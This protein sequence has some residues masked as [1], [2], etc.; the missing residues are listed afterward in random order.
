MAQPNANPRRCFFCALFA[1]LLAVGCQ[2]PQSISYHTLKEPLRL[3]GRLVQRIDTLR[4]PP[5]SDEGAIIIERDGTVLDLGGGVL[6]GADSQVAPENFVGRGIVVRGAKN[7][8]LRNVRVEGFKVG[9]YAEDAPGLTIENCDVSGNYRQRLLSTPFQENVADWLWPHK[10]DENE[11]LRY[12]SGI[13]LLRCDGAKLKNNRARRGQNGI[14]LSK[15]RDVTVEFCDMS[16]L[17]GWGLALWRSTECRILG[18]R[19][20]YCVRGFSAGRFARGQDSAGILMFEQCSD[21]IIAFNSATHGG[22][23]LFIYGGDETL[24]VTGEGG[25]NRNFVFKNDFSHAVMNGIEATFSDDN[26]FVSNKLVDCYHGFWGGYCNKFNLTLNEFANC[27]TGAVIEHARNLTLRENSFDACERGLHLWWDEDRNLAEYAFVKKQGNACK[28]IAIEWCEFDSSNIGIMI[29]TVENVAMDLNRLYYCNAALI[30]KGNTN[31]SL[32]ENLG[33]AHGEIVNETSKPMRGKSAWMGDTVTTTGDITFEALEVKKAHA[34]AE[35]RLRCGQDTGGSEAVAAKSILNDEM[36]SWLSRWRND[37]WQ[38]IL[39][40][41]IYGASR[42]RDRIEIFI[43]PYG[44]NDPDSLW[45]EAFYSPDFQPQVFNSGS[46]S[47]IRCWPT[48]MDFHFN[49]LEGNVTVSPASGVGP[50]NIEVTPAEPFTG[51]MPYRLR[52]IALPYRMNIEGTFVSSPWDI[53]FYNWTPE[54][55]PVLSDDNWRAI[56]S[57]EPILKEIKNELNYVWGGGPIMKDGPRD[58]FAVAATTRIPLPPGRWRIRTISDDGIRVYRNGE[59]VIDH[60][61]WHAPKEDSAIFDTTENADHEIRVEYFEITGH[62]Q[63]QLFI[64]QT[65]AETTTAPADT[66]SANR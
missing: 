56:V 32:M 11:W 48:G 54:T 33:V 2:S 20:D 25:C 21:N 63:L 23:G 8:I 39:N 14:C 35:L 45:S 61:D 19:F 36:W 58:H 31:F 26:V 22:D 16:Y 44:P 65:P 12:G 62:A 24:K 55:D 38:S 66:T 27:K 28:D 41:G 7:V 15:C 4:S 50:C 42:G 17:S 5:P 46:T 3:K 64:E 49:V 47:I 34:P 57:T 10:N 53:A 51:V 52:M 37:N 30:A 1:A 29:D 43:G 13:Y 59:R 60:W 9:I 18:N 6:Q 40:T